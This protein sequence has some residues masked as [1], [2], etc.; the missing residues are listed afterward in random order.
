MATRLNFQ[1]CV[2][3][4]AQNQYFVVIAFKMLKIEFKFEYTR[5][6]TKV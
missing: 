4:L 5:L 2:F 1:N 3:S 6:I